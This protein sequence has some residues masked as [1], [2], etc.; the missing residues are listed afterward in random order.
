MK[1][2]SNWTDAVYDIVRQVP[3]GKVTTYGFV[4]K[5]IGATPRMIGWAMNNAHNQKPK[6]PAHRVV[7]RVGLL[8]GRM[9]FSPPE[10]MQEL[11]EKEGIKIE[12]HQ[13]LNFEAHLWQ[14]E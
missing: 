3:K 7:N 4:A 12:D 9:H 2:E 8:T 1:R 14:P 13:I 10:K 11:L 5:I 6:V